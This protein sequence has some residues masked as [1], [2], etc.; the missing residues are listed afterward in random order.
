MNPLLSIQDI[1]MAS[2]VTLTMC[3]ESSPM[4]QPISW[5]KIQRVFDA[6]VAPS[7]EAIQCI[8]LNCAQWLISFRQVGEVWTLDSSFV[9]KGRSK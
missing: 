2:N 3:S 6:H 9:A 1:L 4:H 7:E 8:S 5:L